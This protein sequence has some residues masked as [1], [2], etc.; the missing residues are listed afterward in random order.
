MAP[1]GRRRHRVAARVGVLVGSLV[2]A[3]SGLALLA[4]HFGNWG[5]FGEGCTARVGSRSADLTLDQARNASAIVAVAVRR[6]LPAR[7]ATIA[8]ATAMQESKL[9][10]LDYG[11]RDSL[12]LFQQRPS[13]G[14]GTAAQVLNPIYAAG[15]FYDA[16]VKVQ[17]Y[18][19]MNINNVAQDVQ[20]S[21]HPDGY[22]RHESAARALASAMTG[23]SAAA[24]SCVI[25]GTQLLSDNTGTPA[26]RAA[27]VATA[28]TGA[29]GSMLTTGTPDRTGAVVATVAAGAEAGQHDWA[30]AEW[31]VAQAKFY[32]VSAVEC[33][34]KVWTAKNSS[35]GW[36][37]DS[38]TYAGSLRFTV[39]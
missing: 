7:A 20:H 4:R 12:G 25:G 11:D 14:W 18:Q 32:G 15:A 33:A 39:S 31:L 30:A 36:T 19:T 5:A 10:N 23:Q 17:G 27:A 16:L 26:T 13:Q 28:L 29:F 35:K 2:V 21:A 1:W 38:N 34:G 8:L 24:F 6:D 37:A 3:G 22:A 9:T